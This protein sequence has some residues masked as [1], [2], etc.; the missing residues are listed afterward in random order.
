MFLSASLLDIDVNEVKRILVI[1]VSRIGDTLLGT[2]VMDALAGRFPDAEI[3]F[4]GHPKR[5]ELLENLPTL[6][7]VG[8][9]TKKVAP[10]KGWFSRHHYDLAVVD[11]FDEPLVKYALR[12]AKSVVAFRQQD[13][14]LNAVLA[15]AVAFPDMANMTAVDLHLL[16][17]LA[18]GASPKTRALNYVVSTEESQWAAR[19][20][21]QYDL[22]DAQPLVGLVVESFPTKPYRDWPTEHFVAVAK[23]IRARYPKARFML[24]GGSL[25]ADKIRR[26]ETELA[27]AFVSFVGQLSLRQSA[28][29]ISKLDLYLGVDTGPTHIAGALKIPMIALYHCMHPAW[30]L[31]PQEHPQL[32]AIQ[33][34]TPPEG[35]SGQVSMASIMVETVVEAAMTLLSGRYPT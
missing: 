4:L 13:E 3:T 30:Q 14:S 24:F 7:Q 27:G 34:E 6:A 22:V 1:H 9:I 18:V 5:A 20:L 31:A 8:R 21:A 29:L 32:V 2:P 19:Q 33:Q 17:P 12:V 23:V 16:L 25:G 26:F 35:R 10:F 11:G 15:T 28:A